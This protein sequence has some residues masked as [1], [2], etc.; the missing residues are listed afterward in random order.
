[1]SLK[2]SKIICILYFQSRRNESSQQ[3]RS[4]AIRSGEARS[5]KRRSVRSDRTSGLGDIVVGSEV[6][7]F[8]SR[9]A[10]ANSL[11]YPERTTWALL[12][13]TRW[14]S[15]FLL[16][17][18]SQWVVF[19]HSLGR[20]WVTSLTSITASWS[21]RLSGSVSRERIETFERNEARFQRRASLYPPDGFRRRF[22]EAIRRESMNL[23]GASLWEFGNFCFELPMG[24]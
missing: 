15:G 23:D 8:S 21:A 22:V 13:D 16:L 12:N 4:H 20:M 17:R 9:L 7:F 5:L 14:L 11:T 18:Y 6:C 19:T 1:M 10:R 24:L 2:I 3:T